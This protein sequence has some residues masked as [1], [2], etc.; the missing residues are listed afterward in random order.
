MFAVISG[1]N[2]RSIYKLLKAMKGAYVIYQ[3]MKF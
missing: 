1:V 3:L 2:I